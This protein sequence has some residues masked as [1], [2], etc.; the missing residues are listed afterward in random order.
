VEILPALAWATT[1]PQTNDTFDAANGH[2]DQ[3]ERDHAALKGRVRK[4]NIAA[5]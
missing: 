1:Q 4:G 2:A 3:A 5:C